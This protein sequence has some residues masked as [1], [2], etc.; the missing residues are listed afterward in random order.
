MG[1]GDARRA[2]KPT[3]AIPET[4]LD[5]YLLEKARLSN[6]MR[7][8][9]NNVVHFF[10]PDSTVVAM[11]GYQDISKHT[12]RGEDPARFLKGNSRKFRTGFNKKTDSYTYTT[13]FFPR[14]KAYAG[15]E[16]EPVPRVGVPMV[17][18]LALTLS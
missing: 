11:A 12:K 18:E 6:V 14:Y 17:Q 8:F 15:L 10:A 9:T 4:E 2:L 13:I 1:Y 7:E 3:V 5:E 16:E